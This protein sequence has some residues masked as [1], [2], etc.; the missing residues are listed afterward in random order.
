MTKSKGKNRNKKPKI[1]K[2]LTPSQNNT[3]RISVETD[4]ATNKPLWAFSIFD[5]DGPWGFKALKQQK[6][7]YLEG[8][9]RKLRDNE[10]MTWAEIESASGGRARGNNSHFVSM[11][12]LTDAAQE[13]IRELKQDDIGSIFSLRLQG[14]HRIYGIRKR[15]VLKILWFDPWHGDNDKAVCSVNKG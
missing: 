3:P 1:D 9:I 12:N 2:N 13:R 15:H 6:I 7:A 4:F 10:S 5:C 11:D 14:Q 8:L